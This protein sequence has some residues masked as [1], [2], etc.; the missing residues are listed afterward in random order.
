MS[1][2]GPARR[3]PCIEISRAMIANRAASVIGSKGF[4]L[5]IAVATKQD[6]LRCPGMPVVF[7]SAELMDAIGTHNPVTFRRARDKAVEAGW[8][9]FIPGGTR[10]PGRYCAQIPVGYSSEIS[11][12][13]VTHYVTDCD[14][15]LD[16]YSD[17]KHNLIGTLID[18]HSHALALASPKPMPKIHPEISSGDSSGESAKDTKKA[19]KER[20][21]VEY[22]QEFAAWWSVYPR[23]ESKG[24]AQ[25]A[26]DKAL[27]EIAVQRKIDRQE[28][29]EWL[30]LVTQTFSQSP[31][32]QAG[33]FTPHPTTWLNQKRYDDNYAEWSKSS[34]SSGITYDPTAGA[35]DPSFGRM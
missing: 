20:K 22:S 35:N 33:K 12:D 27:K 3:I 4:S 10:S 31:T 21:P 8:L 32:G 14:T 30:M 26:F 28:A 17:T 5:V 18:T 13:Y 1:T 23:Q 25:K 9:T 29:I 7:Y 6:R 24:A 11:D 15:H 16:T 34:A 2:D 19:K